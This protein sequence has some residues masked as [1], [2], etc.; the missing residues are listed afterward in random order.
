MTIERLELLRKA[1]REA[2]SKLPDEVK[3]HIR[4]SRKTAKRAL[5]KARKGAPE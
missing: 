2:F 1:R 5:R 3:E 4:S